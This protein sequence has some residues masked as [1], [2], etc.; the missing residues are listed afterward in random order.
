M[1]CSRVRTLVHR[2]VSV[3]GGREALGTAPT[4]QR[5]AWGPAVP[6]MTPAA[7]GDERVPGWAAEFAAEAPDGPGAHVRAR[8]PPARRPRP[9]PGGRGTEL[10]RRRPASSAQGPG[11]AGARVRLPPASLLGIWRPDPLQKQA[12]TCLLCNSAGD[13]GVKFGLFTPEG[14]PG[15]EAGMSEG[16]PESVRVAPAAE[17]GEV[18]PRGAKGVPAQKAAAGGCPRRCPQQRRIVP[19]AGRPRAAVRDAR[20]RVLSALL[21]VWQLCFP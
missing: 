14:P 19:G 1:D 6:L 18:A 3:A 8:A 5:R 13:A 20:G 9:A 12:V 16:F 2:F 11:L 10:P 4:L 7:P 21:C 17:V 15:S